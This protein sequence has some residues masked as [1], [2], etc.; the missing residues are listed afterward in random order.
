MT[1]FFRMMATIAVCATL[2]SACSVEVAEPSDWAHKVRTKGQPTPLP[3]AWLKTPEGRVAHD[4]VLPNVVPKSVPFDF[5]AAK[6]RALVPGQPSVARQYF[7]HLCKTEMGD[8]YFEKA[9]DVAGVYFARPHMSMASVTSEYL[10]HP[11]G[12]EMPWFETVLY[13]N[14]SS[15]QS[16][17]GRFVSPPHINYEFMEQP[18]QG[19]DW[20]LKIAEPYIR[21]FGLTKEK[22]RDRAYY[23]TKA[24]RWLWHFYR[25]KTPMQYMGISMPSAQYGYTWRGVSR[26]DDRKYGISGGEII[27][28]DLKKL[29]VMAVRRM[30]I[31][32]NQDALSRG[33][34]YWEL[35]EVCKGGVS[36]HSGSD[37]YQFAYDVIPSKIKS[38]THQKEVLEMLSQ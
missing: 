35:A 20:E 3:E 9:K 21:I 37:F 4:L 34:A 13:A 24:A 22:L 17:A 18:R 36:S 26:T 30:F 33:K 8:W 6:W 14:G 25:E 10:T 23:G 28:Y 1:Y 16:Q 11:Y 7:E 31:K 27:I 38:S 32:A 5:G 19:L 15:A 2:L 29:K 12:M